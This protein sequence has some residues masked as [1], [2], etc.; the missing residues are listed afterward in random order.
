MNRKDDFFI[1]LGKVSR[2]Q[3]PGELD[4]LILAAHKESRQKSSL[5]KFALV[6]TLA[7]CLLVFVNYKEEKE[8]QQYFE[9]LQDYE[10]V[11]ALEEIDPTELTDE[12]WEVLLEGK[13]V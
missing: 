12:E 7:V 9:L 11:T 1:E 5:F 4:D 13:D 6:P 2:T 10:V 8:V 3:V